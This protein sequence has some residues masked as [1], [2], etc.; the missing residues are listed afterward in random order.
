LIT[1]AEVIRP[2]NGYEQ[3][4]IW[5]A[6]VDGMDVGRDPLA[7]RIGQLTAV[8]TQEKQERLLKTLL[9]DAAVRGTVDVDPGLAPRVIVAELQ[10]LCAAE[11]MAKHAE[12]LHIQAASKSAGWVSSVQVFQLRHHEFRIINPHDKE[13]VDQAIRLIN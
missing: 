6:L 9:Q 4:S 5:K 1:E 10:R 8:V 13:S 7:S 11:G 2:A 3:P 12:P